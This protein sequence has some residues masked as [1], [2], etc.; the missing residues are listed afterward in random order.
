LPFA[1]RIEA[2][3]IFLQPILYVGSSSDHQIVRYFPD[4]VAER[5]ILYA[6][7]T[8]CLRWAKIDHGIITDP[9]FAVDD[10]H[11]NTSSIKTN[12]PQPGF[13]TNDRDRPTRFPI[14]LRLGRTASELKKTYKTACLCIFCR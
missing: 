2:D 12:N 10:L 9:V 3:A 1:R 6:A 13:Y 14:F 5:W 11:Y 8:I 4:A 7:A